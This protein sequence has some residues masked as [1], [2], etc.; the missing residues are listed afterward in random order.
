VWLEVGSGKMVLSRPAHQRV[1]QTV[2]RLGTLPQKDRMAAR[3]TASALLP[4]PKASQMGGYTGAGADQR[5]PFSLREKATRWIS[6][7]A[8]EH[9]LTALTTAIVRPR[10]RQP[11]PSGRAPGQALRL[12]PA[13]P[14]PYLSHTDTA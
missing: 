10:Q 12:R 8:K 4:G 6:H 14:S 9:R 13:A 11:R 2:G 3:V 7:S 5:R 1:T